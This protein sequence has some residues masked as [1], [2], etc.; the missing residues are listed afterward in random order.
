MEIRRNIRRR[1]SHTLNTLVR[2]RVQLLQILLWITISTL[3]VL[4]SGCATTEDDLSERPWT[5][6]RSWE[7][8]I[9]SS[10]IDRQR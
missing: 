7:G 8:G 3:A 4:G 6:P 2:S 5:Q 9:P 1:F 10:I